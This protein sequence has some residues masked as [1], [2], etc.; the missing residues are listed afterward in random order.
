MLIKYWRFLMIKVGILLDSWKLGIF[1][2]HLINNGYIY[3]QHKGVTKNNIILK[4]YTKSIEALHLII[5][6]A[7][8]EA[9]NSKN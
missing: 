9:A 7:N 1:E 6:A 4:V 3:T 8:D 2:R 5:K